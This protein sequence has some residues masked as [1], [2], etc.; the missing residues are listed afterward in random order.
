VNVELNDNIK[1]LLISISSGTC[2][3]LD[4]H[5][6]VFLGTIIYTMQVYV[7]CSIIVFSDRLCKVEMVAFYNIYNI[8]ASRKGYLGTRNTLSHIPAHISVLKIELYSY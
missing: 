7:D 5:N 2:S 8:G 4:M 3:F 6:K 1:T